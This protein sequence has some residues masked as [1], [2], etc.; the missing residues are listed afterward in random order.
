MTAIRYHRIKY[1]ELECPT[2]KKNL[3][4]RPP[5]TREAATGDA[6]RVRVRSQSKAAD[7]THEQRAAGA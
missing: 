1:S 5:A 3:R 2:F 7:T 6:R 4:S